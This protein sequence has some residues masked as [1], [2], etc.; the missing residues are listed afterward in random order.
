MLYKRGKVW[1]LK[2]RF[3]GQTIRKSTGSTSKELARKIEAKVTYELAEGKW[4]DRDPAEQVLFREVWEKYLREDA[5]YKAPITYSRAQQCA[6]HFLPVFVDLKLSQVTPSILSTYKAK[7]FESGVSGTT[8]SKELGFVRRVFSLCK[9]EWQLCKQSPFELF[10]MPKENP[11]RV[12][13][14]K[15]GQFEKI[16]SKCPSWLKPVVILARYTGMRRGKVL[17]LA[18]SQVDFHKSVINLEYTKNGERLTIPISSTVYKLLISLRQ[19]KVIRLNCPYVVHY[20]GKLDS[21]EKVSMAFKRAC[22]HAGVEDFR[23]HDL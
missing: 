1:W 16:L 3:N 21:P 18:W 20:N 13:F 17:A 2:I 7:R 8:V 5:K 10:R 4:F 19:S 22:G 14:L 9:K 6:K 12:R 15:P 11:P 23:F